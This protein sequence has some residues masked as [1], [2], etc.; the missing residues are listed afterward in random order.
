MRV[1]R[2]A[3]AWVL[4]LGVAAAVF[5]AWAYWRHTDEEKV[6]LIWGENAHLNE[7]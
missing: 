6:L 7:V 4:G 3:A 5:G 1:L 2:I